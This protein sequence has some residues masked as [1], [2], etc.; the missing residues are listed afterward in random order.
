MS[1][2]RTFVGLD[3]GT[4][5][6]CAVIGQDYRG[7]QLHILGVGTAPSYGLKGGLVV[8][9]VLTVKA[10]DEAVHRAEKAARVRASQVVT[11]IAGGHLQSHSQRGEVH[12][13]ANELEV[14]QRHV[15]AV[16]RGAA[17]LNLA[18]DREVVAVIPKTFATDHLSD[19][20]DPRGLT[21][22]RLSVEAHVIT[23][24]TN[25]MANLERCVDQAGLATQGRVLQPLAS[26]RACLTPEQRR[27]GV[28]LIDIGGGTTDV[29][30]FVDDACWHIA[31]IPMGGALVTADIARGLRL[32]TKVAEALKVE[33]GGVA[34]PGDDD[35]ATV[36][37]P[38]FDHGAPV[39]VRRRD[40]AEVVTARVEELLRLVRDEITR[41]G[42]YEILPAGAV[43]TGG[44]SRMTG[45]P[46]LA[47]KVLDMPV[48]MGRPRALWGLGD[49]L[50]APEFSTGIGLLL[51]AAAAEEADGW[52][53]AASLRHRGV[54]DR[55]GGW[56]RAVVSP[57]AR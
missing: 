40:L 7:A 16:V 56:M 24:A 54:L 49:N 18:E 35:D 28:V 52:V 21:A 37:V 26:A 25:A 1:R 4:T 10:I 19:V 15:G 33:H 8:D 22:R 9:V 48:A 2:N 51:T 6:T 45:L 14:R 29:A 12:L 34:S 39:V 31:V 11:G 23:G 43:L 27:E 17:M 47:S 55:L 3:V 46:D 53:T 13:P 32:P 44:G 38:G 41:S 20:L 5:K 57:T 30:L 36:A 50:R 42:Y